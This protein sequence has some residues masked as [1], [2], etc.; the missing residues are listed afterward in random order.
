MDA[1]FLIGIFCSFATV[2]ASRADVPECKA[3]GW[4]VESAS[5][6][7]VIESQ[8]ERM[9][10]SL[11]KS[12]VGKKPQVE[13]GQRVTVIYS[14]PLKSAA[15]ATE[16]RGDGSKQAPGEAPEAEPKHKPI[17]DDRAYYPS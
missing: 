13:V 9:W 1:R 6:H 12:D 16:V 7:V 3:S 2:E 10:F 11:P 8:K 14:S 4:V 15:Q 17:I 5:D